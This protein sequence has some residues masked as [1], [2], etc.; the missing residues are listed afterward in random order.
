MISPDVPEPAYVQL[1]AILRE[2]IAART[3][4]ARL[5]SERDLVAEFGIAPMTVRK[6]VRLLAAEGLV[7]TVPGRGTFVAKR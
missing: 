6:S 3:Y 2:R 7:V 1:A 4:T 5:P